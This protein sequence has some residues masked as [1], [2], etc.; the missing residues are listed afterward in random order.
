MIS[1]E[2]MNGMGYMLEIKT[3][4]RLQSLNGQ[5]KAWCPHSKIYAGGNLESIE[6][7]E[8]RKKMP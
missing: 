8:I 4:G 2:S 3:L 5:A 1:L 7:Y 6:M